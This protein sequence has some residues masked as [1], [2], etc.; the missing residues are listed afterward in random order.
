MNESNSLGGYEYDCALCD[1]N[2]TLFSFSKVAAAQALVRDGWHWSAVEE[3][4]PIIVHWY[5]PKCKELVFEME[6]K[7]H[8]TE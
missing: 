4:D 5:C 8:G 3:A 7:A 2:G 1:R 6:A